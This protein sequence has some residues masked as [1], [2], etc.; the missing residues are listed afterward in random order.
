MMD[1]TTMPTIYPSL[2]TGEFKHHVLP[3]FRAADGR[4]D[5]DI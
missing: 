3:G 2:P 1:N 5:V 4:L